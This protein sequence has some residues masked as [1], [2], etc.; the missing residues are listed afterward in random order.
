MNIL[1][2]NILLL[3]IKIFSSND[4]I[5]KIPFGLFYNQ[6]SKFDGDI[7]TNIIQNRVYLNLS[8]GTPPQIL[9]FE[10]DM[11]SQTFCVSNDL[12]N[13]NISSTYEDISNKQVYYS[14]EDSEKGFNSK[15]IININNNKNKVHFILGTK[16]K[17][18]KKNNLGIIGLRIPKRVQYGVYP[19]FHSL[20]SSQI[21]DSYTWT[22]KYFNNISL[23][24]QII[25][26]KDKNNI[27]GELIFGDE[28]CNYEDN[29]LKYDENE[30]RKVTPLSTKDIIY[31][32][33]E[34]NNIYLTFKDNKNKSKIYF[35]GGKTAEIIINYSFILGPRL[36]LDNLEKYFFSKYISKNICQRKTSDFYFYHYECAS[37]SSFKIETFPNI[38]FEHI[39]LE[40]IF[41][42]TYKDLFMTFDKEIYFL[43]IF[44]TWLE[45]ENDVWELGVPFLK[46][47]QMIFNS[48]TKKI[49]YYTNI[50]NNDIN[51]N[52][53]VNKDNEINSNNFSF[54]SFIEIIFAF[55]FVMLL[56]LL[57]KKIYM[58]K[59]K[60]KR[61]FELQDED[62][63]YFSNTNIK[64][65]KKN[66]INYTNDDKTNTNQIIEME[67]H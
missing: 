65:N 2:F 36:F 51:T 39:E 7:I 25:Y 58:N 16:F 14:Y 6:T 10:L 26:D 46:K 17:S 37:N 60:Q 29:K 56:I 1:C 61:P 40:T 32:D 53:T 59:I 54:R 64:I 18:H 11:N 8:I 31:Y 3:L 67:K 50:N 27:I 38:S 23:Y 20:K 24:D 44:R 49:G 22:L 52:S 19:F 47:Y 12:F 41:N 66:D 45:K 28:P 34:F 30:Y 5:Y 15:D 63:D 21:I 43:I 4:K 55:L 13:K 9:P 62:Y 48:D 42:L 35:T 33:I 57:I